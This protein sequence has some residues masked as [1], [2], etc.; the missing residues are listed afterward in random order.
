MNLAAKLSRY[1]SVQ[2]NSDLFLI[3]CPE[4]VK[5]DSNAVDRRRSCT[6]NYG[7]IFNIGLN[8]VEIK[9]MLVSPKLVYLEL[10]S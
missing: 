4:H 3:V 6:Q 8:K 2:V 5:L 1:A 7:F 9:T 10:E